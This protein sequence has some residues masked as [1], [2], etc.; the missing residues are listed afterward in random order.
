MNRQTLSPKIVKGTRRLAREKTMQ[1]LLAQEFS[2]ETW[3]SIFD[4]IFP[5]EF[6]AED[7]ITP[8][9]LLTPDEIVEL[10]ADS[11]IEW[12]T[13]EYEF[14]VELI[15]RTQ[16]L[17]EISETLITKYAD[18]WEIERIAHIDKIVMKI[19]VAEF[20]AF[21]D[22]PPK[23]SINE[24]IEVVKKF[25]TEK[26]GTFVNGILDAILLELKNEGKINKTGRGLL[27]ETQTVHP[28][29]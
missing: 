7:E 21:A 1:I 24:A 5:F 20:L 10:E 18:N 17:Q 25:S 15:R 14:V 6:R 12:Q 13:D 3:Q 27:E 23:V 2:G 29:K 26:S 22:I 11:V 9:R 8:D 16:E 19:A 28:K 4:R